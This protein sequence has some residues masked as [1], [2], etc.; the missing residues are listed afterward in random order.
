VA[1][2]I[3]PITAMLVGQAIKLLSAPAG[4]AWA[5]F[6]DSIGA[7]IGGAAAEKVARWLKHGSGA[8]GLTGADILE[9][10]QDDQAS[11][12][13]RAG[14]ERHLGVGLAS[15][16]TPAANQSF[17]ADI[18]AGFE[19]VLWRV[20][21]LA[22]IAGH[23]I[24]IDGAPQG[25]GWLTLCSPVTDFLYKPGQLP[26]PSKIWFRSS[27]PPRIERTE[28]IADFRVLAPADGGRTRLKDELNLHF[29]RE[30][31]A[32]SVPNDPG[33]SLTDRWHLIEALE[34]TWVQLQ[35]TPKAYADMILAGADAT[36]MKLGTIHHDWYPAEWLPLIDMPASDELQG[37]TALAAGA[38]SFATQSGAVRQRVAAILKT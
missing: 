33:I 8:D 30:S 23:P 13:I 7:G 22:Y 14:L 11:S 36:D 17:D 1:S 9:M 15:G 18:V 20:A 31:I 25:S 28:T 26:D 35:P 10:Q 27:T 5:A 29:R 2:V 34:S 3:D 38:D 32:S 4:A 37:M 6:S 12:A 19:A 24:V 21:S 16:A